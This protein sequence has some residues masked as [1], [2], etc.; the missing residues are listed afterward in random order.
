MDI[1]DYKLR[2]Q[3]RKHDRALE[4]QKIQRAKERKRDIDRAAYEDFIA[5]A[6]IMA[7]T[8]DIGINSTFARKVLS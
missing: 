1:K 6:K 4:R 2:D 8:G 3:Q 7:K 5:T